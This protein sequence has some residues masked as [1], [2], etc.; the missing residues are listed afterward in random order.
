MTKKFKFR[1]NDRLR[2]ECELKSKR[3][4]AHNVNLKRCGKRTVIGLP[5]CWIHLLKLYN[6]R[7]KESNIPKLGMGLFAMNK[8]ADNNAI[9]F[10]KGD[11]IIEYKGELIDEKELN[12]RYG[13]NTAPYGIQVKKD[14]YIDAACE[15]GAGSLAN[16]SKRNNAEFRILRKG[17]VN[18]GVKLV[19]VKNIKNN[20]EIFVDY[21]DEYEF[22]EGE[23]STG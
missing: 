17:R 10:K 9:I 7:I 2:F 21:G 14:V 6:L 20:K 23:H 18:I 5:Y 8:K 11:T 16:H 12:K 22:D 4:E 3:C 19:A 1:V 15:R 13:D